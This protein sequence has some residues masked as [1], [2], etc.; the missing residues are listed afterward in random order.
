M[1]FRLSLILCLAL[2]AV[3]TAQAATT[4]HW[5]RYPAISPDG[6][7]VVFSYKGDLWS[8]PTAGG[9]ATLLTASDAYEYSPVWSHDGAH[10]AF[11]S[12]RHGTFDV[13]VMPAT[14][15]EASRLTYHS[16]G[17]VPGSFT[18]D[19]GAVLFS[20]RRQDPASN[21][22]FPQWGMT[23]LYQVP[24]AGGAVTRVLPVPAN[25]VKVSADGSRLIYHDYKGYENVWRKHHTSAVTRDIWTYDRK[26]GEYQ[27]ITTNSAEDRNPIF[28]GDGDTFV[29]LSER[30]GTF[31]V[32]QGSL[33]NP[34]TARPLTE[35][36]TH[37]VRF[38]SRANDGTLCFAWDGD[39][40]TLAPG[41]TPTM[42]PITLAMDGLTAL[43][44]VT[45]VSQGFTEF[46]LSPNDKEFAYV[47][48]GEIFVSS[49]EGGVTRRIT[50]TPWQER[51]LTWAPD[52]RTLGYAAEKDG[53]WNLY[54]VSIRRE[55]EPYFYASTLLD[56]E[57]IVD[58]PA[59][60][61][62]PRFSPDGKE[63]AYLE[64]R[65]AIHVVNLKSKKTRLVLGPEYNY[66]YAD[67]D[68]W[69]AW[70]PDSRWLLAQFGPP[71]R[72]MTWEIGLIPA[73]GKGEVTNLTLSGYDDQMP[74]WVLDGKAMIWGTDRDGALRQG[75]GALTRDVH[76]LFFDQAAYDRFRLSKEDFALVKEMEEKAKEDEDKDKDDK[77]KKDEKKEVEPITIDRKNLTERTVKL[78]TH[79]APAGDW[80]LSPDGE[81]LYTLARFENGHDVWVT[82]TRTHEAKLLAKLGARAQGFEMSSDGKFLVV[83]T[84]AGLRKVDT[85]S[86]E[87]KPLSTQGE[88]VL[89]PAAERA[90]IFDHAWRL[91]SRKF[92]VPDL[93][94]V[95]W[96]AYGAAYRRFLPEVNNNH[97][98][99]EL[100]S[101]LLGELNASHTGCR[102][103]ARNPQADRTAS[104]G[105]FYANDFSKGLKVDEVITG[106]PLDRA[107]I[108]LKAGCVIEKIDGT[109]VAGAGDW[110]A[111][112]NRK[113]GD[114][115]LLSVYDPDSDDRW[116]EEVRPI[117]A[118]AEN[119]LLYQR[120]VRNR[121]DEVT[122]LSDG[123]I[124]YVHVR[125][126]NDDSMRSV[127]EEALGRHIGCEALIV[128]TRFNGGGNI[129][130]QLSDF[131][132]GKAYFDIVPHGQYVGAESWDKWNKPSIVLMG[133]SN[134]SDAHLFPLAYKAK[135]VGQ[136][137]GMP[138]PGTGTFVWWERQIDPTLVF[139]MP[140]G[141]WRGPDGKFA[142][143]TQLEPDI[144]VMNEPG[145]L[146]AGRDQQIEAAVKE[147]LKQ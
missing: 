145:V 38:L 134:Y 63:I 88:M 49:V 53:S 28:T 111:L 123:R 147:L 116:E 122:R 104:L 89:K 126:M 67:G 124:G 59:E 98:F 61:F 15:G 132:N 71:E 30:G 121:R 60:E 78:T 112:L 32:W 9:T 48:R 93:H 100:L 81:K 141:G 70:S 84:D 42:I 5:L 34:A 20:A 62:Q 11:A 120:W 115:V 85:E 119:E 10:I 68:Q 146:T 72:V 56:T 142:E 114:R 22:Q 41:G 37:P 94:G 118:R 109:E 47:F 125:S 36:T 137:L 39:L 45:S 52:G 1:K 57:T 95:D 23:E 65:T 46:V 76:A 51:G 16:S 12:D 117:D 55:S 138:V 92:Y 7:T 90:Y 129:H 113:V 17:E 31:N 4:P 110:A 79:T 99:A 6:T 101:K 35:F 64:N 83:L 140:M 103:G 128:D 133:E 86:G 105:L 75:G 77:K 19:D 40:Y 13:F 8:A 54:T 131:L 44:E 24:V 27:Q 26:S 102:Y 144:K 3:A 127:I 136:T 97:D 58:T 139:G 107:G 14:G 80:L 33:A 25:D 143:N 96:D 135:G 66:S 82:E 43:D 74:K 50:D 91:I 73:D 108:K 21:A 106:G 69:F 130:E 2:L 29:W 18:A 87:A